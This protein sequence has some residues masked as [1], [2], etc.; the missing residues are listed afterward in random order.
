MGTKSN[1]SLSFFTNNSSPQITLLTN[2][3]VGIGT[4]TST[5][6]LT[7]RTPGVGGGFSH[8]DGNIIL[9]S[10]FPG[11]ASAWFGTRSAHDLTFITNTLSV[12][13]LTASGNVGIGTLG[14]T[15]L[16]SVNGSA[17]KTGG[18]SWAV[19]SD[20]RL[21]RDVRPYGDGLGAVLAI[22]PVHFRY[23]SLAKTDTTIEYVG[24]IAQQLREVA[25]YMIDTLVIDGTEYLEV[26]NSAMTYMLVNAVKELNAMIGAQQ[27]E[28]V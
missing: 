24:V 11:N 13:T 18:G 26:D 6:K 4:T 21:K 22:E 15:A 17:N 20:Q 5:D 14:P 27:A 3:N 8:T 16:L 1:H 10:Y 9:G 12:M 25:P 7:V 23:N 19:F 2:G 28:I